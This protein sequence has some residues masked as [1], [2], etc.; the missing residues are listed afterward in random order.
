MYPSR[1]AQTLYVLHS[2]LQQ[3]SFAL[4]RSPCLRRP[5]LA[6]WPPSPVSD[7]PDRRIYSGQPM[8]PLASVSSPPYS[9]VG[10]VREGGLWIF[11]SPNIV[12]QVSAAPRAMFREVSASL[13]S[14]RSADVHAWLLGT[15]SCPLAGRS[16][17]P[18]MPAFYSQ[19]LP[20]SHGI[21]SIVLGSGFPHAHLAQ[22]TTTAVILSL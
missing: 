22:L 19:T 13:V 12:V 18:L 16:W 2:Q 10:R 20:P 4:L 15:S 1:Y 11:A 8:T 7:R 17:P 6:V 21:P 14:A 3:C 9:Y 5:V